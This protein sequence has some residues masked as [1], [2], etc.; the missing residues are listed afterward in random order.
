[1]LIALDFYLG[2][3]QE[4]AVVGT[5]EE[6]APA[7]RLLRKEFRPNKVVAAKIHEEDEKVVRLLEGKTRQAAVTTYLC[8]NFTCQAPVVGLEALAKLVDLSPH[9]A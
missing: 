6:I 9:T 7:L 2:P 1:M 8:Q 5:A 4:F 3:V